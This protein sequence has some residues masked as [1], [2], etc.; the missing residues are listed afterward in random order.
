MTRDLCIFLFFHFADD[1]GVCVFW[2]CPTTP[3]SSAGTILYVYIYILYICVYLYIC[4]DIY[5]YIYI[6]IC[7]DKCM[8]IYIGL[9]HSFLLC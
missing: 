9:S 2:V 1:M 6:Y 3:M 5:I 4:I 8:Y 7:I